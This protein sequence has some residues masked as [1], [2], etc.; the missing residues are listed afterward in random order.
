MSKLFFF[1]ANCGD[2]SAC[3]RFFKTEDDCKNAIE[4]EDEGF[5]ESTI[6]NTVDI[7]KYRPEVLLKCGVHYG[8]DN[9]ECWRCKYA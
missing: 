4:L 9:D 8:E 1:I 7:Q 5:C 2:G 3:L 6:Y